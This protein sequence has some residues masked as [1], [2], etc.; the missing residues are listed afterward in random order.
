[1]ELHKHISQHNHQPHYLDPQGYLN[2]DKY[3]FEALQPQEQ[4]VDYESDADYYHIDPICILQQP[5][6]LGNLFGAHIL[7]LLPL[8]FVFVTLVV[9]QRHQRLELL[10][11][12]RPYPLLLH[13]EHHRRFYQSSSLESSRLVIVS[14]AHL[15]DHPLRGQLHAFV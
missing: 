7:M 3:L 5:T 13:F 2:Y 14:A 12:L 10:Y 11:K 8:L 1:M 15:S 9:P 6:I 4:T